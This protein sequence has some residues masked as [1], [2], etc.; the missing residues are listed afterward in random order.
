MKL[1]F[2][3][4]LLSVSLVGCNQNT[5]IGNDRE[6]RVDPAPTSAPIVA[7]GAALQNVESA[8]IKPETMSDADV[9]ALGG[10][11]GRCAIKL[12]EVGF[13]SFLYRQDGPGAI[14]L[15][16]KLI[17][18]PKTSSGRFEADDLLVVLRPVDEV[19]NAGLKAAEMIIVPPGA[20]EETGYR[21]Y[22]Q[23]FKGAKA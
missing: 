22:I 9:Q 20:K 11:S 17:V 21:G 10:K 5:S 3:L 8:A 15:N 18:L 1:L 19:G 16:G 4:A 14:K 7:A 6:A 23:C 2:P 13:P 12:T